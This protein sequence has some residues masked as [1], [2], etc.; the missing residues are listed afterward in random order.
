MTEVEWRPGVTTR[1]HVAACTGA[2]QLCIF[3]QRCRPG[4]GAPAHVHPGV[5]E[6][7]TVL[8]G[9]CRFWVEDGTRGLDAGETV[10]VPAGARH[11]FTN[12]G[13][14]TLRTLAVFPV[15]APPVEYEGNPG[16]V[17]EVGGLGDG[18]PLDAH[19][20]VRLG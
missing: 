9:S 8:E 2:A 1:L 14:G 13:K 16:V 10:L 4:T 7:V 6:A 18:A 11:G 12:V 20:R 19:R 5:E 17:Y 15:P 3:E